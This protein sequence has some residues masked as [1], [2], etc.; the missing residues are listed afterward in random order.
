MDHSME[1]KQEALEKAEIEK[2]LKEHAEM[3]QKIQQQ[4]QQPWRP[5]FCFGRAVEPAQ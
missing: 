4:P 2:K 5:T 1:K 3:A